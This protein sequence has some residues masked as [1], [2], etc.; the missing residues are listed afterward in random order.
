MLWFVATMIPPTKK[1][2]GEG[3][4]RGNRRGG[5]KKKIGSS[6]AKSFSCLKTLSGPP[7][8]PNNWIFNTLQALASRHFQPS[9]FL[10]FSLYKC[11]I[12]IKWTVL[13]STFTVDFLASSPLPGSFPMK[14]LTQLPLPLPSSSPSL[15][16]NQTSLWSTAVFY[17]GHAL[18]HVTFA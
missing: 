4:R 8:P 5:E 15:F 1:E 12:R 14:C 2:G 7:R 10:L 13:V 9:F 16:H 18:R 11:I 17:L 6:T 3:K